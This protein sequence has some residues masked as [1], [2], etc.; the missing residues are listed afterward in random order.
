MIPTTT[1]SAVLRSFAPIPDIEVIETPIRPPEAGELLLEMLAAPI[2][3]ADLNVIEGKYGELPKV[4]CAIG[5]EGVGRVLACGPGVTG[6]ETGNL[7]LP[8]QK[9]TWSAHMTVAADTAVRLPEGIDVLQAAMLTVNPATAALLLRQFVSLEPGEW[10]VQN[11]SNSGVGRCV[12]QLAASL[13]C[14]TFN[15]VR[16]P[17]LAD[18][19]KALG[20]DC[21][22]E[23]TE[24]IRDVLGLSCGKNRP[25]LALNSVGGAS[26]LALANALRNGGVHVTFGAMGRQPLKVPNGMLIFRDLQFRG[27]WLTRWLAGAS[28]EEKQKLYAD[29]ASDICS[30]KLRQP[31]AASLPLT[32]LPEALSLAATERRAGKILLKLNEQ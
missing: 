3:P 21:V 8:M 10:I 16:R 19:L 2:N 7:V 28:R 29:L 20:A 26:A 30:G 31:V 12:I 24:E 18:E 13:G 27:F 23:E 6:F 32:S 4:P 11:A 5:N 22:M 25:R 17:E 1:I 15:V 9:G 14:K